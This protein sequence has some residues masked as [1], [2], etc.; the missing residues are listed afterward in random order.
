L[1]R[2][3]EIKARLES[4]SSAEKIAKLI[5]AA[6]EKVLEQVDTYFIVPKGRLKLRE[7]V[8][9]QAELIYYERDESVDHR[10]SKFEIYPLAEPAKLKTLLTNAIGV[11]VAVEKKRLLYMHEGT[12]IHLDHVNRLGS[13]IEFEVPVRESLEEAEKRVEYLVKEFGIRKEDMIRSSYSD[14]ILELNKRA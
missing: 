5:S 3:L 13:F 4:I 11:K 7:I 10:E 2:N 1:P 9:E 8:G 12:R 6:F 14:L